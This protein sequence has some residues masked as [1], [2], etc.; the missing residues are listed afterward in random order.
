MLQ[1]FVGPNLFYASR[2]ISL[3]QNKSNTIPVKRK[4]LLQY[5]GEDDTD[6]IWEYDSEFYNSGRGCIS[7]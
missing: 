2:L 6:V 4:H 1:Y 5:R 3:L 7:W